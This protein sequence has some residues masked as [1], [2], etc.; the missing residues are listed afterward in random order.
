MNFSPEDRAYLE[1]SMIDATEKVW[2]PVPPGCPAPIRQ[3]IISE[4]A[5]RLGFPAEVRALLTEPMPAKARRST[6]P[7]ST[8]PSAPDD[9]DLQAKYLTAF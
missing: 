5:R 2:G 6:A 4:R 1:R 8:R 7:N 9:L 3:R